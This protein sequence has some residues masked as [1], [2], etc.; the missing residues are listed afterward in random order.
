MDKKLE[1]LM[2]IRIIGE[3]SELSEL[4]QD[5]IPKVE[6]KFTNLELD[7]EKKQEFSLVI[8]QKP[9]T[10]K[11]IVNSIKIIFEK[12]KIMKHSNQFEMKK[13]KNVE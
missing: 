5:I 7:A 8:Y 2:E 12:I 9:N 1:E 10:F 6:N 3:N 4:I 11:K 13:A